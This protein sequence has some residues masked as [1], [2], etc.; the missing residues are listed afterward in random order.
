[1]N[2]LQAEFDRLYRADTL[3]PD[4]T[5]ALVL[6]LARPADWG[7]LSPLWRGVQSDLELPAPAIA[8]NGKDAFQLW[9][10]LAEPVPL[11]NAQA[12][13]ESLR[14]RYLPTLTAPRIGLFTSGATVPTQHPDSGR[15][16]AFIAP[17]LAAIFS[18]EPWLDL[19]PNPDAQAS[20]LAR[21]ASIK[22]A[23]FQAALSQPVQSA[24][25]QPTANPGPGT[26]NTDLQPLRFLQ[27]VMNDSRIDLHLRIEAAKALLPYNTGR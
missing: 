25:N 17:D 18:E 13:L 15:W 26:A 14:K 22:P 21:I 23:A 6:E 2:T 3:L 19:P 20:V 27:D 7:V 10:S 4:S 12:F 16:S 5:R 11:A 1:M 8:V 24:A 9:F